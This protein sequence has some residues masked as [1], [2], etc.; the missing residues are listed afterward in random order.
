MGYLVRQVVPLAFLA[1]G[2][3]G[4]SKPADAPASGE[5][6]AVRKAFTAFQEALKARDADKVWGLLDDDSRAEAD[7]AARD[8]R[9]AYG[10]ADAAGKGEL[11]KALG[12]SAA[13][14]AALDGKGF[15]KTKRFHGKYDEI[16]GSK[17][18]KASV[19][20]DKATVTY[21]EDDGDKVKLELVKQGGQWKVSVPM[22]RGG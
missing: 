19:Q 6:E 3:W 14:L 13:D 18:D 2:A 20:G 12:L 9:D 5:E 22:P 7:R 10:K 11:E 16:P 8:V 17:V 4:C 15:L 21:V 1:A